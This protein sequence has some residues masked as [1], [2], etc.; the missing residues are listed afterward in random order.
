M[1]T[2]ALIAVGSAIIG[3]LLGALAMAAFAA[4]SAADDTSEQF[5]ELEDL[6]RR[7]AACQHANADLSASADN[8]R[9]LFS[10]GARANAQLRHNGGDYVA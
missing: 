5:A 1:I 4:S 3:A 9:E 8:Y 7:L 10:E 2:T 6:R